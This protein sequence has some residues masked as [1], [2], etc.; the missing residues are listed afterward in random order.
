MPG[1]TGLI[2]FQEHF[3]DRFFDVGIAEQHAVAGAAGMAMSGLRPVVAIYSTFLSRA[4]DQV[5]YDVA[6]HRLPVVFC[7]DRAGITGPDGASHHGLYDM[8]LLSKVPGMRVLAPSSAQELQQMLDDATGLAD[9]GPVAIRYPR[10]A[11]RQVGENEVGHGLNARRTRLGRDVCVLAVGRMV[12]H[13]LRAADDLAAH[14]IE[15][16]VWDVRSCTP[17]DPE[18][19]ADA[20]THA[21]VVTVEDGIR[22]GGIGMAIRDEIGAIAPAVQTTVLGVPTQ[23]VAHGDPKQIMARFGLD[24]P[25]IAAAARDLLR[26]QSV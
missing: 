23:F 10:G 21:A 24:G 2:P 15:A 26:S 1:P 17:L 8:A 12:E 19:I 3:P 5:V 11:A 9:S 18:M 13:S 20:A 6:M 16:T 25:G 22:A 4:W 14:G 7:L